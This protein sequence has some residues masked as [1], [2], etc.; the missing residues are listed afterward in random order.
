MHLCNALL[1]E[2][3]A[4]LQMSPL[5]V[6]N[7]LLDCR[8]AIIRHPL[9]GQHE[10]EDQK[11]AERAVYNKVR[12][13][14]TRQWRSLSPEMPDPHRNATSL[15]KPVAALRLHHSVAVLQRGI[16]TAGLQLHLTLPVCSAHSCRLLVCGCTSGLPVCSDQLFLFWA[17]W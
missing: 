15:L 16:T 7:G 10:H 4:G 3:S 8:S 13:M 11:G 9:Q 5:P 17:A 14:S 12:N 1:Q 2:L 6:R